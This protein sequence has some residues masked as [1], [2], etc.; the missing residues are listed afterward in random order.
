MA[1]NGRRILRYG[2]RAVKRK[3]KERLTEY[4]LRKW[5][6]ELK[7]GKRCIKCGEEHPACIEWHHRDP[8]QKAITP[9][10]ALNMGWT[11]KQILEE[12]RKCDPIC[13]NCHRKLNYSQR[14]KK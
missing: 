8:E 12:L 1:N 11:K 2:Q 6:A 14:Q 5:W 9:S 10:K 7:R 4:E 3:A 13:A